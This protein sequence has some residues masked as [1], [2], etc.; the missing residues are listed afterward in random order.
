MATPYFQ[1]VFRDLV[2]KECEPVRVLERIVTKKLRTEGVKEPEKAAKAIADHLAKRLHAGSDGSKIARFKFDDGN[3]ALRNIALKISPQDID[4]YAESLQKALEETVPLLSRKIADVALSGIKR[5]GSDQLQDRHLIVA[6]F[7][8]NLEARWGKAL[9]RYE[10]VLAIAQEAG[11]AA[12]KHLRSRSL[13]TK[14]HLVDALTRLHARACQV[15]G[16]ILALLRSGYADG[17]HARWRTLH[18]IS[19]ASA[20]ISQHGE[21]LAE[22]Y[23]L[24]EV[25]ES[26]KAAIQFNEHA[27]ALGERPFST[28]EMFRMRRD[29]DLLCK[30]FGKGYRSQYG[31]AAEVVKNPKPTF[32]H[33]EQAANLNH[34]RPYYKLASY[35]VHASAKGAAYRLGAMN[36]RDILVAGPSNAGLEEPGRFAPYSLLQITLCLLTVETTLDSLVYGQMLITLSREA[37]VQFRHAARRLQQEEA[38]ERRQSK[39]R[40]GKRPRR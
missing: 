11:E 7:E 5:E 34:V 6:H 25:V 27:A 33:L 30:R 32:E 23:L 29:V 17:A 40:S 35:N 19:V 28:R 39:S 16:E 36:D 37:E 4:G 31:W 14:R 26:L 3:P 8:A 10:L 24:H 22:K 2:R 20:L 13:R 18:E 21:S 1:K 12:V 9:E 38:H 15:T